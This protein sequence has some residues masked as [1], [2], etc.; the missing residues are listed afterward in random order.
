MRRFWRVSV[1]ICWVVWLAAWPAGCARTSSPAAPAAPLTGTWSGT[2]TDSAGG[3][4]SARLV[5]TQTG[6]G[7]AGSFAMTFQ[8]RAFD[9]SGS[10][11]GTVLASTISLLLAPS[12]PIVCSPSVTLSGT[13]SAALTVRG[14]RLTGTYS[15][16]TCGGVDAGSLDVARAAP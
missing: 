3:R 13:F 8:D 15:R 16:F 10:A 4:G 6:Q 5:L 11:S 7:L 9:R 12:D 2:V 1:V 14:T